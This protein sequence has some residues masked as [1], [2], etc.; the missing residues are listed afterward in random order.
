MLTRLPVV[1]RRLPVFPFGR[2]VEAV[3]RLV[4]YAVLLV[5]SVVQCC[6]FRWRESFCGPVD[7]IGKGWPPVIQQRVEQAASLE[8]YD[9]GCDNI[10]V[11]PL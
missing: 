1:R 6:F 4:L 5:A 9:G 3:G 7:R 11:R 2:P 8:S 10:S